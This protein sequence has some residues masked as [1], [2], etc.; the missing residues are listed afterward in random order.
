MS[1]IVREWDKLTLE[2]H[3]RNVLN[4]L[5]IVLDSTRL[6]RLLEIEA[7][8]GFSWIQIIAIAIIFHDIGKPAAVAKAS[9]QLH[10]SLNSRIL[11][12]TL[13]SLDFPV[14]I[15]KI[16]ISL[17]SHDILG[18]YVRAWKSI[19]PIQS[20]IEKLGKALNL[21]PIETFEVMEALY[22]ADASS[23]PLLVSAKFA[24]KDG[25]ISD[26]YGYLD[27]LRRQLE[28]KFIENDQT[29]SPQDPALHNLRKAWRS[30]SFTNP[31]NYDPSG[32]VSLLSSWSARYW[33]SARS[34]GS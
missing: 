34:F 9:N 5:P 14:S 31:K 17:V 23:Y 22:L 12:R 7:V 13:R 2:K 25:R 8:E 11:D 27:L 32:K 15:I 18:H 20:D 24:E 1:G 33:S 28:E 10:H 21:Q 4:R 6:Q 30:E 3:T 16:I 19:V 26:K 29:N